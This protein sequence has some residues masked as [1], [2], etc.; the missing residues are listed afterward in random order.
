[1]KNKRNDKIEMAI[2]DYRYAVIE[3]EKYRKISIELCAAT[4]NNMLKAQNALYE[5]IGDM[6]EYKFD[7]L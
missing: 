4:E 5:A 2:T 7:V 6:E 3:H 1:M